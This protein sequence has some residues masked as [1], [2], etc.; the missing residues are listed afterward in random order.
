[1]VG[2]RVRVLAEATEAQADGCW[3]AAVWIVRFEDMVTAEQYSAVVDHLEQAESM[4]RQVWDEILRLL[5]QLPDCTVVLQKMAGGWHRYIAVHSTGDAKSSATGEARAAYASATDLAETHL[6][7]TH[8]ARLG[9]ALADAVFQYE[10]NLQL[11][12]S[13]C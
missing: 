11:V 4:F 10:V 6:A 3:R 7:V 8:P 2:P 5:D 13:P 12:P 1:M 9:I